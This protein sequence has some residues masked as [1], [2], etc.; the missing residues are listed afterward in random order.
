MIKSPSSFWVGIALLGITIG[1]RAESPHIYAISKARIVSAAGPV[2]DAGTVVIRNG[3][4]EAVGATV[5]TPADA[6]VIDGSG[7]TVYP[8]LIDMGRS[9][10]LDVP[11]IAEPRE[12]ANREALD[13][14]WRGVIFRS[15]VQAPSYLKVDSPDL[16][17]LAA[18]GITS[19]L[20][21]PGAGVIRGQSA[22][23][24]VMAREED[25][26]IGDIAVPRRGQMV[27]KSPVALHIA[28]NSSPGRLRAYP[29]SLMGVIAFVRQSFLDAQYLAQ[30]QAFLEKS[31]GAIER[32][33]DDPL[34]RAMQPA[35]AGRLPVAFEADQ[36]R[37][38]RRV[39]AMSAE[40]KLDP[41]ITGGR[42]AGALA[43]QIKAQNARVV[44]SVNYPV[45]PAA[46]APDA[47]ETLQALTE[48]A[49][50][51]KT[52]AAL[53]KG[54]VLFAFATAGLKEP[55]DLV[56]NVGKAVQAGLSEAAAVQALTINAARIA[57]LS[58]RLGSLESGKIANVIVTSGGLFAPGTT[59][60]HVFID[61]R[62]VALPAP[63]TPAKTN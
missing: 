3:R 60:K 48:R 35:A 13:R 41:I 2:I 21:T 5:A 32:P 57:G 11:A 47:D 27:V 49:D 33:I 63:A 51:P 50:A 12:F 20:A 36:E 18:A 44:F 17:R 52:P 55:G 62:L 22:F 6:Q 9:D 1:L 10:V 23:V 16:A 8:G 53:E 31:Q 39:L 45:R 26:Q 24:N 46:L 19:V 40:L 28:F 30:Q 25:P 37:E 42:E 38:I 59:I 56:K 4:I 54:G 34:L 15:D 58:D 14:W 29:E 61:G 7:L 43:S